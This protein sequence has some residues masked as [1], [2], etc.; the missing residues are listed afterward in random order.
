MSSAIITQYFEYLNTYNFDGLASLVSDNFTHEFRPTSIN[1]MG[2]P[3][4]NATQVI[5]WLKNLQ[6]LIVSL[7][8]GTP[9]ET[10]VAAD[11]VVVHVHSNGATSLG[12]SFPNE[13]LFI[14]HLSG[15]KIT[16]VK[17]FMDSKAVAQLGEESK[18]AGLNA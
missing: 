1:G 7:N 13:H 10:I 2:L 3:V 16:S 5:D 18:A 6:Q 15:G 17:E 14:F 11:A 8:F 9:V 12:K 4:R